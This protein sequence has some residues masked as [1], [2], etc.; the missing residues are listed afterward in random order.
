MG[1]YAVNTSVSIERSRGEI[2]STLMK[3]G[4]SRFA[5]LNDAEHGR[6]VIGFT[7]NNRL[8]R[9]ELPVPRRDD[10]KYQRDGRNAKRSAD[11]Q[12]KAWDQECRSQWRSLALSIKAKLE[13]VAAGIETFETAFLA[14]IVVPGENKTMGEWAIPQLA[15]AYETQKRMPALIPDLR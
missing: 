10:P 3:Y 11:A 12:Y 14:H 15:K 4:A 2:E 5:Y 6:V 13:S 7:A 1:Q 8:L 9:F